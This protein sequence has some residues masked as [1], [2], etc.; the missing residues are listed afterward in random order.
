MIAY[1]CMRA[2]FNSSVSVGDLIFCDAQVV[3][4]IR[5]PEFESSSWS[6]LSESS[7]RSCVEGNNFH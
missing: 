6:S 3:S 5:V 1:E 4:R 7:F 2:L